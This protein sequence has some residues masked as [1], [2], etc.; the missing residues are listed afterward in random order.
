MVWARGLGLRAAAPGSGVNGDLLSS[1]LSRARCSN[2]VPGRAPLSRG[3]GGKEAGVA[4]SVRAG[5]DSAGDGG[6]G[7]G[8]AT[9]GGEG[10]RREQRSENGSSLGFSVLYASRARRVCAPIVFLGGGKAL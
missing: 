10:S 7:S 9:G 3:S 1:P 8:G 2:L 6:S 4:G 5:G